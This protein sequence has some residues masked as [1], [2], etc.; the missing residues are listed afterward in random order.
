MPYIKN[1]DRKQFDIH[2]NELITALHA[3]P[4]NI[5]GNL[6]YIISSLVDGLLESGVKYKKLNALVGALECAK[7]EFYM[8][9]AR[10]YEDEKIIENGEV[11][12]TSLRTDIERVDSDDK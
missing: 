4:E 2:I 12:N 7:L 10:P 1:T 3:V 5:E 6:N 8:R 9:V 11:Y